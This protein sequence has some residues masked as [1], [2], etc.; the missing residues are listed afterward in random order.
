MGKKDKEKKKLTPKQ[1]KYLKFRKD[2]PTNMTYQAPDLSEDLIQ[3]VKLNEERI[4]FFMRTRPR[5][6]ERFVNERK[7]KS[8]R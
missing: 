1:E 5:Y 2:K 3:Q 7:A 6:P 4:G 8:K